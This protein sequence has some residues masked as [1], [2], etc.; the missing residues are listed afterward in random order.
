MRERRL[1][2]A[3]LEPPEV[4]ADLEV[5]AALSSGGVACCTVIFTGLVVAFDGVVNPPGYVR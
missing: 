5:E 2:E 1:L 4:E 3:L